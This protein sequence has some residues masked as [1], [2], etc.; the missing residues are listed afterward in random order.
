MLK[1]AP[2]GV[3]RAAPR[4]TV[5]SPAGPVLVIALAIAFGFAAIGAQA[6]RLAFGGGS[7]GIRAQLAEPLTRAYARPDIV[8]RKGRLLA[9]DL[10]THSLFADPPHIVDLDETS[11]RVAA[12][13]TDL[14]RAELRTALADRSRRFVWIKRHLG[15][16]DAQRIHD[17]GLPGLSF[18]SEPRRIYPQGRMAGHVLGHVGGDNRGTAGIER[19]IDETQGLESGYSA[20]FS[21]PPVAL[22]L[23]IG[24]QHVLEDELTS[25][26]ARYRAGGASGIVLDANSGAIVAAASLPDFDPAR[27]A[28]SLLADRIDRLSVTT[29][30]LGSVMKVLTVAMALE[31]GIATPA[32]LIDVRVPLQI[33][34]WTIGDNATSGRPLTVREVLIQSSNIGVAHLAL[35]AGAERQRSFLRKTGLLDPLH[36]EAGNAGRP[37]LPERWSEI[38]TATIA[39]GHGI[40]MSP[41]QFAAAAAAIVNGGT[42]IRPHFMLDQSTSNGSEPA[43]VVSPATSAAIR[44]MLRRAVTQPNGTGRRA[45]VPGFEVGGKTGTAEQAARGSY[46]ARSVISSFL[47][48]FP[49]SAPRYVVLVSLFE[50]K[51]AGDDPAARITAG[52]NAAPL[53]GRII[54]R[55][56]P[57]LGVIPR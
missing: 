40:A 45:D 3:S 55:A 49:I 6:L 11:E 26:R 24:A 12:V 38:E 25:A 1:Q 8:D 35:R 41:L 16:A 17:L 15:P 13:L 10:I 31:S 57:I 2:H 27:P 51:P 21:R 14:D 46:Q 56:A 28:E 54:A 48:V 9:T 43:R 36:T 22:T 19:F 34:R 37:R 30:E 52:V 44:D 20:D 47:A 5:V 18:R 42:R 4:N 53:A 32:T 39:Y 23:D 50:P 7:T 29:W 33:G